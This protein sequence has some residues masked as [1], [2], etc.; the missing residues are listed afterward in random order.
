M[1]TLHMVANVQ[2]G[3]VPPTFAESM[4]ASASRCWVQADVVPLAFAQSMGA[5]GQVTV[6]VAPPAA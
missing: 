1:R 6:Y 3:V 4:A 2:A 5:H